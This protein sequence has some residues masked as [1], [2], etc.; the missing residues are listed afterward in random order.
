MESSDNQITTC[1]D[2]MVCLCLMNVPT[3]TITTTCGHIFH[4][5]CISKWHD[6]QTN[7]F[8][9]PACRK[10]LNSTPKIIRD[11]P[12]SNNTLCTYFNGDTIEGVHEKGEFTGQCK[13]TYLND[14]ESEHIEPGDTL[15]GVRE[16]GEFIGHCKLTSIDGYKIEGM[17][18]NG[19]TGECKITYT[20]GHIGVYENGPSVVGYCKLTYP[21]GNVIEGMCENRQFFRECKFTY[22]NG[23]V[24]YGCLFRGDKFK[25]KQNYHIGTPVFQYDTKSRLINRFDSIKSCAKSLKTGRHQ[26]TDRLNGAECNDPARY[27]A[28]YYLNQYVFSVTKL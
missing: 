20:S 24:V 1:E 14:N 18:K 5:E 12:D 10:S 8:N 22:V 3:D 11:I 7:V 15:E 9:C 19:W 2:C 26:I 17:Y 6:K 28:N 16:N 21:N 4:M 27:P 13:Y 25:W 23:K